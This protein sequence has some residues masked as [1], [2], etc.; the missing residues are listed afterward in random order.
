MDWK[1]YPDDRIVELHRS[2]VGEFDRRVR[3][4]TADQWADP[5]PCTDWSVRDLVNHLTYENR[6]TPHLLAGETIAEV[7][8][9]YDGDL[10]GADPAAAWAD[11][12][13]TAL[14]AVAEADLS[15]MVHVSWGSIPGREYVT[16]L[17]SDHLIHGWDLA[18]GI[19]ADE[20]L[21]DDIAEFVRAYAEPRQALMAA[22]NVFAPALEP[23]AGSTLAVTLL[24]LYGRRA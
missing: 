23:L 13:G 1:Q 15:A 2:A 9:R 11:A 19:G 3:A 18:R 20:T 22:S 21:A 16:Q 10:L 5:T 8:D 14:A 7:G 17:T 12:S 6:W 24:A 4:I